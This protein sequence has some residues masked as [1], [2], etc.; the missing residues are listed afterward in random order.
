MKLLPVESHDYTENVYSDATRERLC[1]F[2][3]IFGKK[4]VLPHFH[5][6]FC[7]LPYI[8]FCARRRTGVRPR[9]T[10]YLIDSS[11]YTLRWLFVACLPVPVRRRLLQQIAHKE[12]H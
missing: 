6:S 3:C 7:C 9:Q 4:K 1:I 2:R 11:S 10:S 5:A 8:R 12:V